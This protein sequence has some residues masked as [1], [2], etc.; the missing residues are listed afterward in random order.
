MEAV[1]HIF[2]ILKASTCDFAEFRNPRFSGHL[3]FFIS[4][5]SILEARK[6]NFCR[7][8]KARVQDYQASCE[9]ILRILAS[10]QRVRKFSFFMPKN[11]LMRSSEMHVSTAPSFVCACAK[12]QHFGTLKMRF[13]PIREIKVSRYIADCKNFLPF[14][15]LK[16]RF[17]LVVWLRFAS[18]WL[19]FTSL[20]FACIRLDFLGLTWLG[21]VS[22][23]FAWVCFAWLGMAWLGLAWLGLAWFGFAWLGFAWL[24]L[25]SLCL[26]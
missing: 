11:A 24:G 20:G 8:V 6:F 18:L 7:V 1:Q 14:C 10:S 22:F 9:Q 16:I 23:G 25:S 13:L 4:F 26:A 17:F 2:F 5:F 19:G 12:L 15:G 21:F 3:A